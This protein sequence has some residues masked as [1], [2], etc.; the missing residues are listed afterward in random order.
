MAV[1]LILL[2]A[3]IFGGIEAWRARPFGW[4]AVSLI[5]LAMVWPALGAIR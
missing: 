3:V 1:I 4:A 2:L 5:A